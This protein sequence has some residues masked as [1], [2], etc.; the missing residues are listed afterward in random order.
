M[1]TLTTVG[2]GDRTPT[3]D[4]EKVFSIIAELAGC[5]IFGIVAGSLGALAMSTTMSERE[6]KYQREQV[7]PS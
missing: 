7:R 1:T 4:M 3:T 6:M 5:V 2:Y